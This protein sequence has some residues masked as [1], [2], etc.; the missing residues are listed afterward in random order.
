MKV[1][2][3][4]TYKTAIKLGSA[5]PGRHELEITA[6][7][8]KQMT[9]EQRET[10]A[11]LVNN[12]GLLCRY[13][14]SNIS[15]NDPANLN[16]PGLADV[17]AYC[18]AAST[19]WAEAKAEYERQEAE[20]IERNRIAAEQAAVQR[21]IRQQEN[22]Q[23]LQ[24]YIDDK[25][26]ANV[27]ASRYDPSYPQGALLAVESRYF[28]FDADPAEPSDPTLRQH[29]L[30]KL[31][32][33]VL[34]RKEARKAVQDAKEQAKIDFI[35]AWT[36]EHGTE[37]QRARLADGLLPRQEIIY[38]IAN[39]SADELGLPVEHMAEE[40]SVTE[41][42]YSLDE[43]SY[44]TYRRCAAIEGVTIDELHSETV[45]F[46]DGE[47]KTEISAVVH[48]TVGPFRFSRCVSLR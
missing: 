18:D 9:T 2:F 24:D 10:L 11:K 33:E 23:I 28:Y 44:G 40:D 3:N 12:Q 7:D 41:D 42:L 29:A 43:A 46:D 39:A 31:A 17:L 32:A 19:G 37:S 36:T 27:E 6:D 38:E 14:G 47:I 22:D 20:R 21:Q 25:S 26:R 5:Q 16:S 48:W 8:L 13:Y 45:T 15:E 4:I 35:T 1:V 30:E 34:A